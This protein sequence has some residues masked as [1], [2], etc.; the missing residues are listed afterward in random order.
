MT[1]AKLLD[2]LHFQ[3]DI[4]LVEGTTVGNLREAVAATSQ[5]T[6]RNTKT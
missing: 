4:L 1:A 5:I 3:P 2:D 6:I